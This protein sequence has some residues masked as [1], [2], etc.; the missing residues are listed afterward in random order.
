MDPCPNLG[1]N[2]VDFTNMFIS[3]NLTQRI[4]HN[5]TMTDSSS[6]KQV[7]TSNHTKKFIDVFQQHSM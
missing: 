1:W 3:T 4:Q 7:R 2:I 6:D 5:S